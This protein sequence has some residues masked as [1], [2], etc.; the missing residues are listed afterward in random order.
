MVKVSVGS[1]QYG[2]IVKHFGT[3]NCVWI[4]LSDFFLSKYLKQFSIKCYT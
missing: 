4:I 1:M 3:E 2:G